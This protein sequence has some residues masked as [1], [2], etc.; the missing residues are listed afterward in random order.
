MALR[1]CYSESRER[2]RTRWL[3]ALGPERARQ[4]VGVPDLPIEPE[5][6][7]LAVEW[8]A[9]RA[10]RDATAERP[11]NGSNWAVDASRS[12]TGHA[13]I[14]DNPAPRARAALDLV[15]GARALTPSTRPAA[16]PSQACRWW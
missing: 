14:A 10:A 8:N 11:Q 12:A 3:V 13:L 9:R 1:L 5:L 6:A 7:R 4:L 16:S 15:P 2:L